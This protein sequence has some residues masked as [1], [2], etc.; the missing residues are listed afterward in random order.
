MKSIDT[1]EENVNSQ[2]VVVNNLNKF[3]I[4]V[5]SLGFGISSEKIIVHINYI[6]RTKGDFHP[7]ICTGKPIYCQISLIHF[8]LQG[9][10]VR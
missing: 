2:D 10:R 5:L 6:S 4:F 9:E 3:Q 1:M 8:N 7:S